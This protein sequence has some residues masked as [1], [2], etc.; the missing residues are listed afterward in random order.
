MPVL[1]R[2]NL[3][4]AVEI[5]P[6]GRSSVSSATVCS[7][8]FLSYLAVKPLFDAGSFLDTRGTA[9]HFLNSLYLLSELATL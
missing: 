2:P 5:D 4:C 6:K 9:A 7:E 3:T 8:S 1:V